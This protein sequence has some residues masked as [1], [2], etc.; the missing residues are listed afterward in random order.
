[1]LKVSTLVHLAKF[2]AFK[3]E[4]DIV[5]DNFVAIFDN[6][7]IWIGLPHQM[8]NI[9]LGIILATFYNKITQKA[10]GII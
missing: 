4:R 6:E 5:Y 8:Q 3:G 10:M 2:A 1:L 7:C 9:F